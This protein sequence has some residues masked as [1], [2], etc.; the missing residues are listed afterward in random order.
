[1]DALLPLLLLLFG[2]GLVVL[3][4]FIPSL[5]ILAVGATACIV[6]ALYLGFS[7]S[8]SLGLGMSAAVLVGVPLILVLAFKAF[9]ET[10][11]G[12]HMML[13]RQASDHPEPATQN[14]PELVGREGVARSDL[15]PS[16][17][18][19]VDGERL[20]V[21]TRGELVEAGARIRIIENRGNRIVVKSIEAPVPNEEEDFA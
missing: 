19:T 4:V 3:E 6:A 21:V 11:L 13:R 14:R 7:E 17:V 20:D 18:A 16:G 2:F 5:G 15:R 10:P 8:T 12:R 9:P 1:M